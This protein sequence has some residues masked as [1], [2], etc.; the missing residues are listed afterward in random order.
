[1]VGLRMWSDGTR[2]I[3][4]RH[5]KLLTPRDILSDLLA[6]QIGPRNASE[7]FERVIT[8]LTERMVTVTDSLGRSLDAIEDEIE[9]SPSPESRR[10]LSEVRSM[11]V[12]LR[13]FLAPQR[14]AMAS[15]IAHPPAWL[16]EQGRLN[17]RETTDRVQSYVEDL[18]AAREHALV[19]KDQI[20]SAMDEKMNR[21]MYLLSIV[22]AVFLPLSFGTGLLGMNVGGIPGVEN[23]AAFVVTCLIFVVMLVIEIVI[24]R[25]LKW[26]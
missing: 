20:S 7:L 2:L 26:L 17:L 13:R 12:S 21:N 4:I 5:R 22:A 24:F 1:M 10:K 19:L 9:D 11:A 3:T 18:D 25:H 23:T 6:H 16:E 15:L 14:E 8:R